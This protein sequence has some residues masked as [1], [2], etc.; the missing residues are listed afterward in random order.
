MPWWVSVHFSL[1]LLMLALFRRVRPRTPTRDH[2]QARCRPD[3]RRARATSAPTPAC[4]RRD[5]VPPAHRG[6]RRRARR[7]GR[8]R[9]RPQRRPRRRL[10]RARPR[11]ARDRRPDDY[12]DAVGAPERSAQNIAGVGVQRRRSDVTEA[13]ELITGAGQTVAVV[14]TGIDPRTPTS[15]ARSFGGLRLPVDDDATATDGNGHGTHVAGTIA[16]SSTTARRRRRRARREPRPAARAR[17]PGAADSDIA[18]AFDW[19]GDHGVRIVN[20]SLGGDGASQTLS[21]TRSHDASEHAVRR[22]RRQRRHDRQGRRQRHDAE[23]TRATRPSRTSSASVRPTTDDGAT[24][25]SNHG[26]ARRRP[27]R[28]RRVDRL[29]VPSRSAAAPIRP[30]AYDFK[31]GTSMAAPHVAARRRARAGRRHRSLNRPRSSRRSSSTRRCRTAGSTTSVSG[32]APRPT[33]RSHRALD[34]A[35]RSTDS[36]GDGGPM[37]RTP[38]RDD[39]NGTGRRLRTLDDDW[40]RAPDA[41]D[42]CIGVANPTRPTRTATASGDACDSTST[43]TASLNAV[44]HLQGDAGAARRTAAARCRTRR[45]PSTPADTGP[46]DGDG[47][48]V[49]DGTDDVP[50]PGR[51][52]EQRLPAGRR[53]PRCRPRPR[54]RSATVKVETDGAR[55]GDASRSSARRARRWVRVARKTLATSRKPRD[56]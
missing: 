51:G 33:S 26:D 17:R 18:E 13:W 52:D 28:A 7:R 42:N 37:P 8:R 1:A 11:P 12:S 4:A 35:R 10:R 23:R 31:D 41:S 56:A 21:T 46:A 54:K 53:S 40:D 27:L 39:A 3:R 38:A 2:R 55:H 20:A 14:D 16:A 6:R 5:A 47:D 45:R 9:A 32:G 24:D 19:A 50:D 25:F 22:Q 44:R 29:H 43:A 15:R 34:A 30:R 36:D 48:G 49:A